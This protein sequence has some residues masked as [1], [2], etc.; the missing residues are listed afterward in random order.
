MAKEEGIPLSGK[1]VKC[2]RSI[3]LV[4]CSQ[5][6]GVSHI[7]SAS[8]SGKLRRN[9]IRIVV[10]DLVDVEVSAYDPYKG[11]ITYRKK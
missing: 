1:V 3:F 9:Y 11:R 5:K 10:G 4:E 2:E 8:L 7:V 6:E